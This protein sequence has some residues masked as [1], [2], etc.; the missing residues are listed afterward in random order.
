[1]IVMLIL[2]FVQMVNTIWKTC[3]LEQPCEQVRLTALDSLHHFLFFLS[4]KTRDV[5]LSVALSALRDI[6]D[7]KLF[8]TFDSS[9][10]QEF[11]LCWEFWK[12][13]CGRVVQFSPFSCSEWTE[14]TENVTDHLG[15]YQTFTFLVRLMEKDL[16][17]W[18][19]D[20]GSS[21]LTSDV[22][23]NYPL[24]FYILGGTMKDLLKNFSKTVLS[25]YKQFLKVD[26]E[27]TEVRK[28]V[29]IFAN[30]LS[31]LDLSDDY[32]SLYGGYKRSLA[33]MICSVYT[34]TVL[35]A[36]RL[37]CELSLLSPSWLSVLVSHRLMTR[38]SR[39][40]EK[41]TD[42]S[43]LKSK[44]AS[45]S[46]SQDVSLLLVIDNFT[47]KLIGK[48]CQTVPNINVIHSGYQQVHSIFRAYWHYYKNANSDF[49]TFKQLSRLEDTGNKEKVV[50][51]GNILF[52]LTSLTQTVALLTEF[53]NSKLSF[54]SARARESS[55]GLDEIGALRA[56]LFAMN[57]CNEY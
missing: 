57:S 34:E 7:V 27:L 26:H 9:N 36:T 45:L 4:S 22:K 56:L 11:M 21:N 48:E 16:E 28:L 33:N 29:A 40:F 24:V 8:K 47:H 17:I 10:P 15:P 3:L 12:E 30:C 46:Q 37:Y 38:A 25:L 52:H 20:V 55:E 53:A 23:F 32:G 39:Q 50:K 5:W 31:H 49:S 1:M 2:F 54:H 18:W 13:I 6:K 51:F 41:V 44:F 42:V 19:K 43:S 14:D 35:P